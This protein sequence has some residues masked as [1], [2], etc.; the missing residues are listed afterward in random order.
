MLNLVRCALTVFSLNAIIIK[1]TE[2]LNLVNSKFHTRHVQ[3]ESVEFEFLIIYTLVCCMIL[4]IFVNNY[5]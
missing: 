5:I 2:F 4:T 1:F 3:T